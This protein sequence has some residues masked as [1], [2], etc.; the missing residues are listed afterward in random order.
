MLVSA[1]GFGGVGLGRRGSL[2]CRA[3]TAAWPAVCHLFFTCKNQQVKQNNLKGPATHK[4]PMTRGKT[5][6]F[7]FVSATPIDTNNDGTEF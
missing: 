5:F 1:G 7:H 6:L 4:N 2:C 3:L